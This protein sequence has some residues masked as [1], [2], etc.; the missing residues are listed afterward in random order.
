MDEWQ[1]VTRKRRHGKS[2]VASAA[3]VKTQGNAYRYKVAS[4]AVSST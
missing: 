2:P 1:L 4:T 3:K